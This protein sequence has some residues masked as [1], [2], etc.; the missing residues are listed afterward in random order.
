MQKF[1]WFAHEGGWRCELP[2]GVSLN[3]VPDRL[4]KGITPKAA[5]RLAEDIFRTA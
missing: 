2:D 3:A 1:E 5:Q 4:A